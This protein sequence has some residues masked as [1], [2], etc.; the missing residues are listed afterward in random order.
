V[1]SGADTGAKVIILWFG[2][3]RRGVR[4]GVDR[5]RRVAVNRL[6]GT[7][8]AAGAEPG[9]VISSGLGTRGATVLNV[10]GRSDG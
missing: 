7:G 5:S 8:V 9:L 10:K 2:E 1:A 6:M 3:I 4:T